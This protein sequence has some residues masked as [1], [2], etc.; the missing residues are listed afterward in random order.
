MQ[1]EQGRQAMLQLH[2]SDQQFYYLLKYELYWKF[3]DNH[4]SVSSFSLISGLDLV[5]VKHN[6]H[7]EHMEVDFFRSIHVKQLW[8]YWGLVAHKYM[9]RL[10][11]PPL[12]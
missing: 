2:L 5:I 3:D 6:I 1:L 12:V 8:I 11:G 7:L 9:C 10:S 4:H